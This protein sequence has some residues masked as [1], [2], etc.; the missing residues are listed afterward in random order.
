MFESAR[1]ARAQEAG[2]TLVELLVVIVILG[3]LAAIV[4]F[5]VGGI[6]D[7]GN[8][9]AKSTDT[10]VLQSAE[11]AVFAQVGYYAGEQNLLDNKY[12]RTSS[13]NVDICLKNILPSGTPTN[14]DTATKTPS[15][16]GTTQTFNKTSSDYVVVTAPGQ[17]GAVASPLPAGI[18]AAQYCGAGYSV[19]N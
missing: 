7:K 10:S 3:I 16:N 11:E 13:S 6:T 9:A 19:A 1:K 2:F 4:V 17:S 8:S 5:A 15:V 18:T 14:F 12:M